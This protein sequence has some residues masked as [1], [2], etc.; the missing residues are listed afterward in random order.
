MYF[1]MFSTLEY[2]KYSF[3]LNKLRE[4]EG[5]WQALAGL[6]WFPALY[7]RAHCLPEELLH[8]KSSPRGNK[9]R[10]MQNLSPVVKEGKL[11]KA[12]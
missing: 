10:K 2:S 9:R 4:G 3:F 11:Y 1:P 8:S 7:S 12:L 6:S 5:M